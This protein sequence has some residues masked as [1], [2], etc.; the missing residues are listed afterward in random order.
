MKD[1]FIKRWR[2]GNSA[3]DLT[4]PWWTGGLADDHDVNKFS[5][6]SLRAAGDTASGTPPAED[7]K[8]KEL[9]DE[10]ERNMEKLKEQ[11][12]KYQEEH[13]DEVKPGT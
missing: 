6:W 2:D 1:P 8:A 5:I 4:C 3:C 11:K 12:K 10:Y 13:P 9:E 7:P